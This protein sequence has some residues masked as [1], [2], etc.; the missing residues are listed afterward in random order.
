MKKIL[1]ALGV[2]CGVISCAHSQPGNPGY[3]YSCW[4]NG[5]RKLKTDSSSEIFG[6]ETSHYGFTLNV[7]DFRAA[8]LGRLENP[9]SYAEALSHKGEKLKNLAPAELRIELEVDGVLYRAE[10]CKAGVSRDVKRLAD[11]RLWESGRFVQHFDFQEL[12]FR[13]AA[14]VRLPCASRLDLVAWPGTLTLTLEAAPAGDPATGAPVES[15]SRAVLRLSLRSEVGNW[16]AE[17]ALDNGWHP[18]QRESLSMTCELA[19]TGAKSVPLIEVKTA[20][21]EDV[22]VRFDTS[23]NCYVAS[24][25][26]LK[27]DFASGYTDIR[28]Y[29]EFTIT[30]HSAGPLRHLPFLLDLRP[31]ANITGLCPMLC[32]ASGVPTGIPVQLSKNWHCK[33]M[34]TYLMAYAML[35]VE[36]RA[37]YT[38][39]VIYGFYGHLPAASHAQLSLVGYSHSNGRWDQLA[40]GCWG[41]TICFDMD[42]SCVDVMITDVRM[43]MTR[44][45]REGKQWGW[46]DAGWGGD[47]LMLQDAQQSKYLPKEMKTAYI[48]HGPCLTD[49]RHCGYYGEN[50]E[51]DFAAQIRTLR[52]DDYSRTFQR[53]EYRFTTDVAAERI[54]LFK[55]GRTGR[56]A[57]PQVAYGNRAGCLKE[58][59]V[60]SDLKKGA[61]FLDNVLLEGAAPWWVALP[62]AHGTDGKDWGTGYRA[63]VIRDFKA[64]INGQAYAAPTISAPLYSAAPA[65]LDLEIGPPEGIKKFRAG[66]SMVLE[67]ELVTLPRMADDYYG[68]NAAFREHLIENPVSWKTTHREARG[69]ALEVQVTGG[70]LLHSY[71]VIVQVTAPEVRVNIFGGVGAVPLRFEGLKGNGD[72]SLYQVVEGKERKFDQSVHGNDYWQSE[73]DAATD[74]YKLTFNLLLDRLPFSAWVLR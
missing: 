48:S 50:R 73:Y 32:D 68:P 55:L 4:L 54:S 28:K 60:P 52:T 34:G 49:V 12:D 3:T 74:T 33:E 1:L 30:V 8:A 51:I 62:G 56:H 9:V 25:V 11:V 2:V 37:V 16:Q 6:I 7:S 43:L 36:G 67:V 69:N 61:F 41:E 64:T 58:L 27:R 63:L 38:L 45:G 17:L 65:N 59:D 29:D 39:R 21:N 24:A 15:Y 42:M 13:S 10:R 26:N 70:K 46:T 72:Y 47:W 66:D 57:T 23:K 35:P 14:G 31:P 53:L 40:I 5:W 44:N 22:A 18:E 20:A 71:P 19:P